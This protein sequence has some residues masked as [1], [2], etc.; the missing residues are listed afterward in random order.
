MKVQSL[1]IVVPNSRCINDCEF[2]VSKMHSNDYKNQMDTNS[3]FF[4]LY[5][6]DYIKRLEFARD[7][8]CNTLMITGNSEPQQNRKFLQAL[9]TM[10]NNLSNP[11]RWIEMQTTGV[12]L[13]EPYLRFLRNHVGIST[14]SLSISSFDDFI[15]KT[16][17][18]SNDKFYNN[19]HEICASIK[20][21]DFNLRLSINLTDA[22]NNFTPKLMFDMAKELGADQVTFR[23]LY[24]SNNETK[25]DKWIDDHCIKSGFVSDLKDYIE[26]NGT[27]LERLEF[28]AIKYDV[29]GL[30]TVL[31]DDC[32]STEVKDSLKYMILQPNCKL[33]SKWDTKA[34]LIF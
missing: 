9:G 19:I 5:E 6:R 10:N 27:K 4:D 33:Y 21:Y 14:I 16:Y 12:M 28:G 32:M 29:H 30:S 25:E 17:L 31:D 3:T 23:V 22:F 24:T 11:F 18:K 1:S 2:C 20:K 26:S 7:N 34:S 13:D 15:N 8:G